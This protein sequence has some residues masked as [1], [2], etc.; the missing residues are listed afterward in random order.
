MSEV[1]VEGRYLLL[2][3]RAYGVQEYLAHQKRPTPYNHDR[4]LGTGLLKGPTE[5]LFPTSEVLL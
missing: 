3:L 1:P 5:G 2:E 4:S